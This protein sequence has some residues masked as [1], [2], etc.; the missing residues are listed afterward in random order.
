M[1]GAVMPPPPGR[2]ALI[3]ACTMPFIAAPEMKRIHGRDPF[4]ET[5]IDEL[6]EMITGLFLE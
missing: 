1:L 5:F 2:Y 4:D 3:G 6:T